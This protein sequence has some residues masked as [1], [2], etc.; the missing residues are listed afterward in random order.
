MD[1]ERYCS[2]APSR[3]PAAQARGGCG[4]E[5][6]A[7]PRRDGGSRRAPAPWHVGRRHGRSG[8]SSSTGAG[9]ERRRRG[10]TAPLERRPEPFPAPLTPP[11]APAC[12]ERRRKIAA[13][14]R[15]RRRVRIEEGDL[16]KRH[17]EGPSRDHNK[18]GEE[19]GSGLC[20]YQ[21]WR[22]EGRKLCYATLKT[23][24][25]SGR[26]LT[27]SRVRQEGGNDVIP[28]PRWRPGHHSPELLKFVLP[29]PLP[30]STVSR[31]LSLLFFSPSLCAV[32]PASLGFFC[33]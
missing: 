22:R 21:R 8:S 30:G 27:F 4:A 28:V 11:L 10:G 6:R 7:F 25:R 3:R 14:A 2:H 23:G 19:A 20:Q 33:F 1:T 5:R 9:R 24:A 12:W 29:S 32:Q 15:D 31:C 17:R 18:A 26:F 16:E 13:R